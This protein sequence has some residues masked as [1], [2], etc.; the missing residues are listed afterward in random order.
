MKIV[1]LTTDNREQFGS[2]AEVTP[3]FGTAMTALLQGFAMIPDKVEVHV[4]SCAKRRMS[5]PEKL[6]SN[7]WFHQP[8]VPQLGWGRSAFVGCGLAVRK[9]IQEIN[10]DLVHAQG[11]E[12]DCAVSLMLSGQRTKILTIH[13]HMARI[14]EITKARF[15]SYYWLAAKLEAMAVRRA[16]GVVAL[17]H[18]TQQRVENNAR[19]TWVVPNAVDEAFLRVENHPQPKL[20]LCVANVHVWKQQIELMKALDGL[21]ADQRPQL[22]FLG[23][24]TSSDYGN[25]FRAAVTERSSWCRYEGNATRVQLRA[26]LAK[27]S[28]VILPSIED[29]CPMVVLE[30]MA[31]GVPVAASNIGGIPDLVHPGKTGELFDPLDPPSIR[32]A[33]LKLLS[34]NHY[35]DD[36]ARHARLYAIE[37]YHPKSVAERHLAIYE[38]LILQKKTSRQA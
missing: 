22:V 8:I 36:C 19:K 38:D 12:R 18:Y 3:H 9:L 24:A 20:A 27:A 31:A 37:N 34:Q 21:P 5:K 14:A 25:R 17:T 1:F 33:V 11:T 15:P 16:D 4:I 2:Y 7:I 30:S 26:W 32:S 23:G 6:A 35:R 28:V 13:G 29:N 10:P